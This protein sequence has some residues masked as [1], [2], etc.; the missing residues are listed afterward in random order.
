MISVSA[1]LRQASDVMNRLSY[2]DADVMYSTWANV[3]NRTNSGVEIVS[4]NQL[5]AGWLDLTTTVNL[6]NNHI[7]AWRYSLLGESGR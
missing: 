1:Y 6:Y 7:S 3:S 2:I 5:F 4:K